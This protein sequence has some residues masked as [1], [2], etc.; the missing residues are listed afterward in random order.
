MQTRFAFFRGNIVPIEEATVDIRTHSFNYG[1]GCFEGIRGYW[2]ADERQML[3]FQLVEHYERLLKS[4]SILMIKLPYTARQMADTTL[5]LLRKEGFE[6]D[7]YIR[8]L[9]YKSS[10]VIGVRLH[11][12]ED[13]LAIYATPF[14]R[15][16]EAEEGARVKV[17][18]WRRIN[19]NM[20]PARGKIVG[21]YVNSALSKT[22]ALLDGYDEAIVLSNNG[23]VSE[24]SAENIFVVRD[25]VL[26]TPPVTENILEG[27]T[28][29]VVMVLAQN[30]LGIP[31]VERPIDR[32]ELYIADEVFF[33]GTGVQIAAIIEIDRRAIGG[34]QMG[35]IVRRLRS[36][37][38]DVV[39]GKVPK[40]RH[41]CT[42][43]YQPAPIEAAREPVAAA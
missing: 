24:G 18:S 34:G 9:A 22:E 2:N 12:L 35:P 25:G 43:V 42:P 8:P 28:R 11:D 39:R 31:V 33:T 3:V 6:E 40:Y 36:L 4:C 7:A 20:M 41:W 13:A 15:Y 30:E 26:Y 1:T 16:V 29:Q 14:G 19:D 5:E 17:S 27:I 10:P 32:S 23:H 38:F 37:Y 21:A